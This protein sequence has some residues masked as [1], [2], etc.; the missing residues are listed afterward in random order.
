MA[1]MRASNTAH[2]RQWT[3]EVH[4]PDPLGLYGFSGQWVVSGPVR[5][6]LGMRVTEVE[7]HQIVMSFN[8]GETYRGSPSFHWD[9]AWSQS[10]TVRDI[11][12][13]EA[14]A[15]QIT[16][17]TDPYGVLFPVWPKCG[18]RLVAVPVNLAGLT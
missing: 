10:V 11:E 14:E 16:A 4:R 12:V 18:Y 5:Y 17:G 6:T 8:A 9:M 13:T 1:T 7:A 15:R 3:L 2:W